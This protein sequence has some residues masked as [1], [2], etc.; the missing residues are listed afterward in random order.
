MQ[1]LDI[2]SVGS[3]L[4]VEGYNS[5]FSSYVLDAATARA[6]LVAARP[7]RRRHG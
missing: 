1:V 3:V 2:S 7:P 5:Q 4:F 6:A